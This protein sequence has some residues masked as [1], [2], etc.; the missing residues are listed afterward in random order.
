V[1]K[2]KRSEKSNLFSYCRCLCSN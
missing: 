1:I 2:S